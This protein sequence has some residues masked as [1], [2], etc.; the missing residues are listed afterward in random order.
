MAY[1]TVPTDPRMR[2]KRA[3]SMIN[4]RNVCPGYRCHAEGLN[5][6]VIEHHQNRYSIYFVVVLRNGVF[7]VSEVVGDSIA[8]TVRSMAENVVR[9]LNKQ[10]L[11]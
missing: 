8:F 5:N 6:L 10:S 7:K 3:V 9:L 1:S 2:C 11:T 4:G